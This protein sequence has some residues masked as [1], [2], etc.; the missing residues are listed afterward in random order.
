MLTSPVLF[1]LAKARSLSLLLS[2]SL[3]LVIFSQRKTPEMSRAGA[4]SPSFEGEREGRFLNNFLVEKWVVVY[5]DD[6][7]IVGCRIN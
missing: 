4:L 1:A 3:A 2:H 6:L 5:M 7:K